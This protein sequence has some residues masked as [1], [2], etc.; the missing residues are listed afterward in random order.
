MILLLFRKIPCCSISHYT[1]EPVL[2]SNRITNADIMVKK[3]NGNNG[4]LIAGLFNIQLNPYSTDSSNNIWNIILPYT[5]NV[6]IDNLKSDIE[7]YYITKYGNSYQFISNRLGYLT[8][9][10]WNGIDRFTN[11]DNSV[12]LAIK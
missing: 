11:D 1:N 4:N 8:N 9:L 7:S 6:D 12:Q 5:G 3:I 2:T 10:N